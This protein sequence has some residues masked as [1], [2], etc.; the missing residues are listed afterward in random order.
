MLLIVCG[1]LGINIS[2]MVLLKDTK[3]VFFVM[4]SHQRLAWIV[5]KLF[6][7]VVKPATIRMVLNIALARQWFIHQ[8]DV[9]N[10][11][12]HVNLH[13]TMYIHQPPRLVA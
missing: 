1:F 2:L 13:E 10:A 12:P 3:L 6:S 11:F 4:T 5:M 7:P 8:L 9:K